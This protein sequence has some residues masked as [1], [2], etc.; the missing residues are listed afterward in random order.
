MG[1]SPESQL[2]V[3]N[4]KAIVHPIAGTFKRTGD[5][6]T[7]ALEA[8]RL[9]LDPKEN[10]EHVM[11][12]DLARND[13]S[14]VCKKVGVTQY[15]KVKY[16]SHVIHLVSEV[17]GDVEENANPFLLMAKTFPAG[18]LSGAPKYKAMQLIEAYEKTPRS[19]YGGAIGYMGFDGTSNQA[20]MIR[21]FLST[22]NTLFY[23]AGAGIV[24]S[25]VP[26]LE[27]Q[28]VNNKLGALKKAV[29]YATEL[30]RK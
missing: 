18:T 14:R 20:I 2:I 27:L 15:R 7:D 17:T 13:L 28:E 21:S 9:L 8:E 16:Y 10:A 29:A 11:L 25:S 5:D 12:V 22:G 23:Q 6:I 26:A 4:G 24:S 1:S 3:S 30:N 19:F